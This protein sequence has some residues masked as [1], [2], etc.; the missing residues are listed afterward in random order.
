[1]A[2]SYFDACCRCLRTAQ[3]LLPA[4]LQLWGCAASPW[5]VSALDVQQACLP[6]CGWSCHAAADAV[7]PCSGNPELQC[8]HHPC[9]CSGGGSSLS[10]SIY[11]RYTCSCLP[12]FRPVLHSPGPEPSLR[13]CAAG[14]DQHC[15]QPAR[16]H[17]GRISRHPGERM[18]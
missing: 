17:R 18:M 12:P 7:L 8:G 13:L 5:Q 16:C 10:I 4:S 11:S 15:W 3:P 9:L 1:M 14:A 6:A 2:C